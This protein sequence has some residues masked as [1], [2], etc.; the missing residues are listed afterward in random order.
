MIKISFLSCPSHIEL[1]IITS[2]EPWFYTV[3]EDKDMQK[4][5]QGRAYGKSLGTNYLILEEIEYIILGK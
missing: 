1:N 2:T 3:H 5:L 4:S